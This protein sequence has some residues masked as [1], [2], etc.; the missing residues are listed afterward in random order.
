MVSLR[1]LAC[2]IVSVSE[3]DISNLK[4]NSPEF[5][6]ILI[7]DNVNFWNELYSGIATYAILDPTLL[8]LTLADNLQLPTPFFS[9]SAEIEKY[10]FWKSSGKL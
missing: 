8:I 1:F 6:G 9:K 4:S 5:S 2:I 3:E 10:S 7:F